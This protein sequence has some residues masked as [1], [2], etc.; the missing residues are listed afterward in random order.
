MVCQLG[1][2]HTSVDMISCCG[3]MYVRRLWFLVI[4]CV[5]FRVSSI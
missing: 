5:T 3:K 1:E 4:W 2:V